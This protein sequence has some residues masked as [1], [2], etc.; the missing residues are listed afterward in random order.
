MNDDC[1]GCLNQ[2]TIDSIIWLEA[3]TNKILTDNAVNTNTSERLFRCEP[4]YI[5]TDILATI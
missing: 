3:M 4:V 2:S 5:L 1:L